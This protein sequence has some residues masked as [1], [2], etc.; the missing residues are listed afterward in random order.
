MVPVITPL[1]GLLVLLTH[2]DA[3][4]TCMRPSNVLGGRDASRTCL[5]SVGSSL[6]CKLCDSYPKTEKS[7]VDELIA[8][9]A[10]RS[11]E[12]VDW[13]ASTR[14]TR[15]VLDDIVAQPQRGK[16]SICYLHA[17]A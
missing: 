13:I 17:R 6:E 14:W 11:I 8:T 15:L 12:P 10:R 3:L 1:C 9:E 16:E 5:G 4:C 2:E 7:I